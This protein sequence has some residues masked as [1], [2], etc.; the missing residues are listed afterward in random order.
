MLFIAAFVVFYT[1]AATIDRRYF[2]A[3]IVVGGLL[4]PVEIVL[5]FANVRYCL[6]YFKYVK[7][8]NNGKD[9]TCRI[10]DFKTI[11]YNGKKWNVKYSLIVYY[12]DNG[13]EK[14]FTTGYDFIKEEYEYL[15]NLEQ[16]KCRFGKNSL[17]ITE[18][19]PESVY[20]NLTIVGKVDSKFVRVFMRVWQIAAIICAISMLVV[21]ALTIITKVNAYLIIGSICVFSLNMIFGIIYAICFFMGKC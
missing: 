9:G 10:A 17:Y 7:V 20:E 12:C 11:H 16:I 15:V 14:S 6:S 19:I 8:M 21:I 5:L 4:L 18:V 2:L 13:I 3:V 1:N